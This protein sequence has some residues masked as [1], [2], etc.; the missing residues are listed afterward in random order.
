MTLAEWLTGIGALLAALGGVFLVAREVNRRERRAADR[1]ID[2]LSRQVHSLRTDFLAYHG[3]AFDL[4]R[5]LT[6]TG[7]EVPPAPTLHPLAEP[8]EPPRRRFR[9][10]E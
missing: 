8:E 9:R 1:Q 5:R 6:D 3:W 4:A 10:K 2:S 7:V